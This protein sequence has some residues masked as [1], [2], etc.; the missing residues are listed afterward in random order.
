M[1]NKK[2]QYQYENNDELRGKFTRWL[3]VVLSRAKK[4]YI[5]AN[6]KHFEEVSF[7]DDVLCATMDPHDPYEDIGKTNNE[8]DFQEARLAK[9]FQEL[10][11]MRKEVLRLMFVEELSTKEIA[12][13]LNI[14]E[15]YVRQQKSRA[16]RKLRASL[17]EG[18]DDTND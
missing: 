6:E 5:K 18:G 12:A 16:F 14:S 9:A 13:R 10:P 11:L 15:E 3:D 8:F 4:K 7:D 1:P 17:S 2:L